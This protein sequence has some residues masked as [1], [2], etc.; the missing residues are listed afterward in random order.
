MRKKINILIMLVIS[1]VVLAGIMLLSGCGE[2]SPNLLTEDATIQFMNNSGGFAPANGLDY[3][4]FSEHDYSDVYMGGGAA[5]IQFEDGKGDPIA[6][7]NLRF[8]VPFENFWV[9]DFDDH[10]DW[11]WV[12]VTQMNGWES[13]KVYEMPGGFG[14][15]GRSNG[16]GQGIVVFSICRLNPFENNHD[17]QPIDEWPDLIM[18]AVQVHI[19]AFRHGQ[20]FVSQSVH[21]IFNR[22]SEHQEFIDSDYGPGLMKTCMTVIGEFG[23]GGAQA[24]PS[25]AT[26][27]VMCSNDSAEAAAGTKVKIITIPMD[28]LKQ[29]ANSS[30]LVSNDDVPHISEAFK[31]DLTEPKEVLLNGHRTM[32]TRGFPFLAKWPD[33]MKAT[34]GAK[35]PVKP[36]GKHAA[37]SSGGAAGDFIASSG[38][39]HIQPVP[40]KPDM[41]IDPN[42]V[43]PLIG[44]SAKKMKDFAKSSSSPP[45]YPEVLW[46]GFDRL[47]L[48]YDMWG[49]RYWIWALENGFYLRWAGFCFDE[50]D[51]VKRLMILN[52]SQPYAYWVYVDAGSDDYLPRNMSMVLRAVDV[53]GSILSR[54]KLDF[55]P[56][57]SVDNRHYWAV[58]D[59]ILLVD[60]PE[61][62]CIEPDSYGNKYLIIYLP[63]G[64][65]LEVGMP[66]GDYLVDGFVNFLDLVEWSS[67]YLA[68]ALEPLS[69]YDIY[70]KNPYNTT[71]SFDIIGP[72][73]A[74]PIATNWLSYPE[75]APFEIDTD[76]DGI[77]DVN[78]LC[79]ETPDDGTDTDGDGYG[80]A[81]DDCPTDSNKIEPGLSGC[82]NP[83]IDIDDDLIPD[84]NDN[85]PY[86]PNTDQLDSDGDGLGNAC[87]N[88]P[89]NP[90]PNQLDTD[91]DGY[92]DICDLCITDP[93]KYEPGV[94]GC[95]T[96]DN[97]SDE[98]GW[99]D[100]QDNCITVP[101][102]TQVDDDEDGVGDICDNCENYNPGQED[103]DGDG[104]ADA[105]EWCPFDPNKIEPGICG[106]DIPDDDYDGD[107]YADECEDNCPGLYN[108]DQLD[109]DGDLVGNACDNCPVDYNPGQE[110]FDLDGCGDA[111]DLYMY[112]P[113]EC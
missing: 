103:T 96:P 95:H 36:T 30:G 2:G 104:Y 102:I 45:G 70:Y 100:C 5:V 15:E 80:D 87:D 93:N 109:P 106:C 1:P 4:H 21:E 94:C 88:C 99:L 46:A 51:P 49:Q 40:P 11:T 110:D 66:K 85:C 48:V 60:A 42:Y 20:E 43:R 26:M 68:S 62:E 72:H 14:I 13:H 22:Y 56:Q 55:K 57:R 33:N 41:L 113:N 50:I 75:A 31:G 65:H 105:C 58:S 54:W 69:N 6:M 27:N 59:Y 78:D 3:W 12:S 107:G 81:C 37:K 8:Y 63:T 89:Y 39:P 9:I 28:A 52:S 61:E 53:D 98:D 10:S 92:G 112:D 111:C 24:A 25:T 77:P 76:R 97:D 7:E 29:Q 67:A 74:L 71:D 34:K 86:T 35:Y 16:A 23:G 19:Q 108:P 73:D 64:A 44:T 18:N 47:I 32:V 91:G 84:A 82:G 90:D 79:P 101:N 17:P 38:L 83:D